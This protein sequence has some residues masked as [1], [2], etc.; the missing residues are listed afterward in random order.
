MH[1]PNTV[2]VSTSVRPA[3]GN[4]TCIFAPALKVC[5]CSCLDVHFARYFIDFERSRV[6]ILKKPCLLR[7]SVCLWTCLNCRASCLLLNRHQKCTE[8][9][10]QHAIVPAPAPSVPSCGKPL[11]L[12]RDDTLRGSA[13]V[14]QRVSVQRRLCLCMLH[15]R[16]GVLLYMRR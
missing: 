3:L 13:C 2:G 12:A 11:F 6:H 10:W 8:T 4:N 15:L 5:A 14:A 9:H 7:L 16:S 1:T